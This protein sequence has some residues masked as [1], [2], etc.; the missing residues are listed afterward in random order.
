MG[1]AQGRDRLASLCPDGGITA[2]GMDDAANLGKGAIQRQMSIGIR[3]RFTLPFLDNS[4]QIHHHQIVYR[5]HLI[6]DPR[7][8][9][10]HQPL[11]AIDRRHVTPGKG[12]Q[13]ITRQAEIGRQYLLFQLA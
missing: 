7:R 8:F 10:H 2:V 12:H 6:G 5:H 13:T 4:V 1:G 3:G 11:L 9:D